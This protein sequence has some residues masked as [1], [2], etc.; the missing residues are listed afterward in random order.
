MKAKERGSAEEERE[1]TREAGD[2]KRDEGVRS[3]NTKKNQKE[4]KNCFMRLC[5]KAPKYYLEIGLVLTYA[6]ILIAFVLDIQCE[7]LISFPFISIVLLADNL[8][9]PSQTQLP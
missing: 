2:R 1:R 6:Y 4:K 7:Q 3:R 9:S 5:S 8:I